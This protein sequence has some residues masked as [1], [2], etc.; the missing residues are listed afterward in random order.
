MIE[1]DKII[2]QESI[3]VK[4][5]CELRE[6]VGFQALTQQQAQRVLENTSFLL[7]AVYNGDTVGLLRILTDMGTDA[8]ITDVIVHQDYQGNGIGGLLI[9]KALSY[10][11][12]HSF[13][14]VKIACSLYA[15]PGKERFYEKYGFQ[16]LPNDK[17]GYGM[18]IEL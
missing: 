12:E 13:G 2:F 18:L 6:R 11:K 3:S 17:Y 16:K 1:K 14:G 10:L 15:N 7:N 8:Y 4:K 5:F 9:Q